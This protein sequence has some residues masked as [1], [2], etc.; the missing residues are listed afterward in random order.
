DYIAPEQASDP[1]KADIRADLYS[2]G[3]ALYHLLT[4][5]PPFPHGTV[6]QKLIAHRERFAA[7]VRQLCPEVPKALSDVVSRL[8][9]KEP[10]NRYRTPAEVAQALAPFGETTP[11]SSAPASK[12]SLVDHS[13][14]PVQAR[15]MLGWIIG[16]ATLLLL[17][18]GLLS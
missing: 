15:R 14:K 10:D 5:Q 16:A 4:G 2:L 9:E 11:A 12:T 7:P 8:M 3:C 13:A 17:G 6:L 1:R 18:V